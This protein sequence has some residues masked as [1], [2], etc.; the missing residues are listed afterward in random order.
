MRPWHDVELPRD[1]TGPIPAI[2]EI[3]TGSNSRSCARVIGVMKM[4]KA[5]Q[6]Y[7]R[8][9]RRLR[10]TAVAAHRESREPGGDA[11]GVRSGRK[12]ARSVVRR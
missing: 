6:L 5:V 3:P 9:K 11:D 12:L 2:I 4:K 10:T 7:A 1:L 8:E